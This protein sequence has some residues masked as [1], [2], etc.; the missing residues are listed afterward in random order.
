MPSK[1]WKVRP[2]DESVVESIAAHSK[3]PL[4]IARVL[5]LRGFQN[6]EEIEN[7][8]T[9]R[10]ANLADPA[11]LPG[12]ERAVSR[13]WQAIDSG[14]SITVFGDYD[15]DGVTSSALLV[16]VL[17]VLGAKVQAFIP[18]RIE[19]GYGLS[20][21]ALERCL[22]EHGSLLL[23]TVDC[24]TNSAESVD[25]AQSRG[26]DVI[27]TD[28]HEPEEQIAAAFTLINPKLGSVPVLENLSGVGVA[29]KLAHALV[30]SGRAKKKPSA[31]NVDLRDYLD[32]VALGTV[33]DIVP[34]LGENRIVV[35]HGLAQLG[36]SKW[37]GMEALKRVSCVKGAPDTY[38]LG[39]QLGPRINAVGRIGQPMQALRLLVTDDAPEAQKIAKLL[40][41]TNI[42]RRKIEQIMSDEAFAEIDAYFDPEKHF[43]LVVAKEGWHPG[44][45]GIVASRVSRHYRRP[46]I[47]MEIEADGSARGSCRSVPEYNLL[48]GLQRCEEHL[49]KFGGHTMAA[50]L[51]VNP[52]AID[53]L[54][55]AF[56][57]AVKTALADVDLSPVQKIDSVVAADELGWDFF[58]QL[59]R[60]QPFGQ[61][62][63]EPIWALQNVQVSGS[64]RVVG[65]K[66]LK[67]SFVAKGQTF[68]AIAFSYPLE[69]LPSGPLDIAF[70]LKENS[71]NGNSSLQ[72]QINDIR[73]AGSELDS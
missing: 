30:K 20:L 29:F 8:L 24:G 63:P 16:R 10:L 69:D 27:V 49:S 42:E 5:A 73:S 59:K 18:D 46:A 71:W 36:A 2:V 57:D 15:V 45:V 60:L 61:D 51:V 19:E 17:T 67:L 62:N 39:F 3:L 26:V 1:L 47:V 37:A 33:A 28:H 48:D 11:L 12:V 4:P 22:K 52:G 25:Y 6:Q 7:Y 9:P 34:L 13:V 32:I 55:A 14:E 23:I 43:G 50:G 65:K 64:P 21:D 38:H 44:V 56:N 58:N 70:T 31:N 72:L 66:H 53:A 41:E 35:R 40:D 54:K 68:D